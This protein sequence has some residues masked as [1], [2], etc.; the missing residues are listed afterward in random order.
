M[1][2]VTHILNQIDAADPES[3]DELLPLVYDEMRILVAHRLA[4]NNLDIIACY[5]EGVL[6]FQPSTARAGRGV[7]GKH[8]RNGDR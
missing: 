4:L 6:S 5:M 7:V 2:E 3:A 1:T 8:V